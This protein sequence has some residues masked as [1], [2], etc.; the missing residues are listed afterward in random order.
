MLN[1]DLLDPKDAEIAKLK[2]IIDKFKRYDRERKEYYAEKLQRLGELESLL[3]EYKD[4]PNSDHFLNVISRQ[5][6][7]LGRLNEKIKGMK[8]LEEY[9]DL[10]L[11][12]IARLADLKAENKRLRNIV[13]SL[14]ESNSELMTKLSK[15]IK[16]GE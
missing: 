7:E 15:Y 1:E 6:R 9:P 5:R 12:E 3:D 8:A 11:A 10:D 16:Y 13:K 4:N 2:L 14:R